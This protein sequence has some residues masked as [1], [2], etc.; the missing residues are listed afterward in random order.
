MKEKTEEEIE[1]MLAKGI[2]EP[3]SSPWSFPVV[4]VEKKN[5]LNLE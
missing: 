2:V 4:L 3:S 1:K 5:A